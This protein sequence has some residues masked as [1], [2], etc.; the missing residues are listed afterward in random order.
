MRVRLTEE[1]AIEEDEGVVV[2]AV[3]ALEVLVQGRVVGLPD[4]VKG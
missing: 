1:D 2:L 4:L 3:L